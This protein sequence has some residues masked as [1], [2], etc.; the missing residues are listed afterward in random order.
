[1]VYCNNDCYWIAGRQSLC[2]EKRSCVCT[3]C[4]HFVAIDLN[5]YESCVGK[6][7]A[8][9]ANQRPKSKEDFEKMYDPYDLWKRFGYIVAGFDPKQTDEFKQSHEKQSRI[10]EQ[11]NTQKNIIIGLVCILCAIMVYFIFI[12]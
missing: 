2:R 6:C 12:K 11:E 1:M 3:V 10:E 4:Q 5:L 7:N 9:D 8:D